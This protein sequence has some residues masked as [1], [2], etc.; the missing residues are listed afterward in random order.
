MSTSDNFPQTGIIVAGDEEN[1][2]NMSKLVNPTLTFPCW[3]P[4]HTLDCWLTP[5]KQAHAVLDDIVYNIVHDILLKTHRE[6]KTARASTAAIVV[7]HLAAQTNPTTNDDE[8]GHAQSPPIETPAAIYDNGKVYLKSNPL[9][10]TSDI[11]CT[12]CGLPRLLYP[13]DGYGAKIPEPGV[14]YCRKHPFIDKPYHDIYGQTYVPLGPGRGKKKKDMINPL[15]K[16]STP[17]GSASS[18]NS[19]PANEAPKPIPFPH[20]K[21]QNCGTFLPIKRMSNHMAKCIGG[22]GRDSSRTALLKIQN[23]GANGSGS[24]NGNT[25][26]SSRQS[27]PTSARAASRSSPNKRSAGDDFD[28]DSPPQKKKKKIIK[29]TAATKLKPPK[30]SKSIMGSQHSA[31]NLSFEEKAPQS[32]DDEDEEDGDGDYGTVVVE[33]KAKAKAATKRIKEAESK[34]KWLHGK[35][36]VKPTLPPLDT[37][38]KNGNGAGDVESESSQTLSSPN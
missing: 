38:A 8:A 3:R 19:P 25:S 24:Q 26:P 18:T 29:K 22:G 1:L 11:R 9:R 5:E 36:G 13:T 17:N 7:E 15:A 10:T 20:A 6:E 27:T 4:S 35:G 34:K 28:S 2:D 23:G 16:E 21:C 37:T 12:R 32:D 14:E 31:S 33:P 30:T